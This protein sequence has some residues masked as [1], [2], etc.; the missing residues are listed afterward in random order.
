MA[1]LKRRRPLRADPAK[2]RDWERRSRKRLPNRSAKAAA[3]DAEFEASR[4]ERR[5][6]ARDLCEAPPHFCGTK[7]GPHQGHH[8]HHVKR[9]SQGGGHE[10]D[11]LRWLCW[12]AHQFAH[13]HPIEAAAYGLLSLRGGA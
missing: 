4:A 12:E 3:G 9:R 11:N 10:V 13:D 1:A 7:R 8:A 2:V 6:M 5:R